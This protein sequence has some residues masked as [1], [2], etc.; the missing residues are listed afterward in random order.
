MSKGLRLLILAV[1]LGVL[2]LVPV[3]SS[4]KPSG[5]GDRVAVEN[6]D[7]DSTDIKTR[8]E[9]ILEDIEDLKTKSA[10]KRKAATEQVLTKV[11]QAAVRA[12]D[13]TIKKLNKIKDRVAKM[14][15]I[16]DELKAEL[17]EKIDAR[18]A[19]LMEKKAA[20]EAATTKEEVKAALGESQKELRSTK[21]IIKSVVEAI[22]KTHL[23]NIITRLE[24][25]LV[26]LEEKAAALTDT[27][28]AEADAVIAQARTYLETAKT[29][30]TS[31]NLIEAKAD[32]KKAHKEIVKLLSKVKINKAN[33]TTEEE[34]SD[35]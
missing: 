31:G 34:G 17:N 26:K 22:H 10:E 21:D 20:V 4:A 30:I 27:K 32:I 28:K 23:Q 33:D 3:I 15:N 18:I 2:A 14:K 11:K 5:Q 19:V 29:N 8:R 13:S 7:D 12:I 9:K 6:T 25:V 35:D 16:S 1:V 24:K